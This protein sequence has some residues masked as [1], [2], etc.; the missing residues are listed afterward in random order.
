MAESEEAENEVESK[1]EK[2]CLEMTK[3][4]IFFIKDKRF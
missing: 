4:K 1:W 3:L 2:P